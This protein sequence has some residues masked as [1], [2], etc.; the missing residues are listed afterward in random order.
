MTAAHRTLPFGTE[1]KVV[2]TAHR[3]VGRGAHQ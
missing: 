1:V 3:P 2:N